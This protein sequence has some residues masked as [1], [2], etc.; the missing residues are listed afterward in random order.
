MISRLNRSV[1]ISTAR[2]GLRTLSA[3][4]RPRAVSSATKTLD[5]PPPPTSRWI[6]YEAPRLVCRRLVSSSFIVDGGSPREQY[7][8]PQSVASATAAH[9]DRT[10]QR[11]L[12][13]Y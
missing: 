1:E 9:G 12:I 4:M 11:S 5:M 6:L 8:G 3:T 2:S 10:P 7:W 13:F